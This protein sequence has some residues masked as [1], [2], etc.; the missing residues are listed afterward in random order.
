LWEKAPLPIV[1][2]EFGII[3]SVNWLLTKA[4]LPII[5]TEFGIVTIVKLSLAKAWSGIVL[6][7]APIFIKKFCVSLIDSSWGIVLHL[8]T[9]KM[10]IY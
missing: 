4:I 5:L 10:P 9:F 1:S 6:N 7:S 3:T 8:L 2:T